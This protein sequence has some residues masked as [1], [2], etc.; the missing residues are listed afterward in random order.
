[1]PSTTPI[2]Y[3]HCL[4][5]TYTEN[6]VKALQRGTSIN[7]IAAAGQGGGRLLADI[8]ACQLPNS[9]VLRV[10]MKSYSRSY[11]GFIEEL[12][13]QLGQPMGADQKT[14]DLNALLQH[15]ASLDTQTLWLLHHFDALL[16]NPHNDTGFNQRFFDNLNSIKNRANMALLC[17]TPQP[18]VNYRI[19][20]KGEIERT[21]WLDLDKRDLMAWGYADIEA[22]FGRFDLAGLGGH[23]RSQLIAAIQAHEMAYQFFKFVLN[24]LENG[25][26]QAGEIDAQIRLWEKQFEQQEHP[27][28]STRRVDRG[29]KTAHTWV[30]LLRINKLKLLVPWL[31]GQFW[32]K[33]G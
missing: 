17:V 24:K 26:W 22:E 18:H 1:M 21:S 28:L 9:L 6:I 2:N 27:L 30:L 8:Q 25:L 11:V 3:T 20:I 14:G 32:K 33:G 4:R 13:R 16:D 7:L 31:I 10:D 12:W 23:D 15:I 19:F 5:P 29:F